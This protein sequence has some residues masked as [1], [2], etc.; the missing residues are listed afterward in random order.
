[1]RLGLCIRFA[2]PAAEDFPARLAQFFER[3]DE[4]IRAG[5]ISARP[6]TG[7]R[8]PR[9]RGRRATSAGAALPSVE[10]QSARCRL[11]LVADDKW[12]RLSANQGRTGSRD[13]CDEMTLQMSREDALDGNQRAASFVAHP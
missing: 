13:A 6:R 5:S 2:C 7:M 9:G 11:R 4:V 1:M 3:V 10:H 12:F 8:R